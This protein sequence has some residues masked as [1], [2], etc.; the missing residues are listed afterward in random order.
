MKLKS[1]NIITSV[2]TVM[3]KFCEGRA[4][5]A[6]FTI[7]FQKRGEPLETEYVFCQYIQKCFDGKLCRILVKGAKSYDLWQIM[8]PL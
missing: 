4:H 6:E 5:A 1:H 2:S 3:F 7:I 8:Q